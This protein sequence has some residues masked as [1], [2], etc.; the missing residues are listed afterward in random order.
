MAF[1]LKAYR[2]EEAMA[3]LQVTCE[4]EAEAE[5]EAKELRERGLEVEISA[6]APVDDGKDRLTTR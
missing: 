4:T 5:A 3:T 1:R 6:I 2:A